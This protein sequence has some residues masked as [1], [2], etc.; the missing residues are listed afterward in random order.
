MV[1]S[2]V[3]STPVHVADV[4]SVMSKA[5][6][7]NSGVVATFP[8]FLRGRQKDNQGAFWIVFI[9]C[10]QLQVVVHEEDPSDN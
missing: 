6:T 9:F 4:E 3:S 8:G 10:F 2:F 7:T 1:W 5:T